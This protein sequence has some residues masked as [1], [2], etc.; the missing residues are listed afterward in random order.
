MSVMMCC[1]FGPFR[2]AQESQ[3]QV[4]TFHI[5]KFLLCIELF[6]PL[7]NSIETKKYPS[8]KKKKKR[9]R[10]IFETSNKVVKIKRNTLNSFCTAL[11]TTKCLSWGN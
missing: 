1:L 9:P 10:K 5:I 8:M 7:S 3:S 11:K 6:F 2:S 4:S